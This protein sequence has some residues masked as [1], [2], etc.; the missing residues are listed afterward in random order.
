VL[1][2]PRRGVSRENLLKTLQSLHTEVF[3]LRAGSGP[4]AA[5]KRLLAYLEWTSNAS[6]MLGSQVT[7]ADLAHLVLTDRY[8]LLLSGLAGT[9][10]G[11]EIEVQRVVN[12]LVSLELDERVAA[13]EAAID[14][15]RRQIQRWSEYGA[16]V[17]PDSSFYIEHEDKLEEVDFGPLINVWES[18]ITVLVPVAIVDELDRLKDSGRAKSGGAPPT[19]LRSWTASSR[20][21]RS[22]HGCGQAT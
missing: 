12:G 7:N 9:L 4:S 8:K 21:Q 10:T 22:G 6:R 3:N 1:V 2:T 5:H 13:F 16:Y 17:V 15:L 14:A 19:A 18:A 11:S 20:N